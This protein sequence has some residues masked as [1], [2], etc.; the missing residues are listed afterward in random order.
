MAS[1]GHVV[2][3]PAMSQRLL[4]LALFSCACTNEPG[5]TTAGATGDTTPTTDDS[6][7]ATDTPTSGETGDPDDGA[8][9]VM[10]L[11]AN[12]TE[13]EEGDP[14]T[15]TAIVVDS[16]GLDTIVGG[17]LLT[18]DESGFYGAFSL[19]GGG[20]FQLVTSWD[21]LGQTAKIEFTGASE[22]RVFRADF[23]DVDGNHGT[24]TVELTLS[25]LGA[26]AACDG[27]C[28][29]LGTDDNCSRCG[30]ACSV[31][32]QDGACF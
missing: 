9:V 15:F 23:Q 27:V 22:V 3:S 25:C 5:D 24:A 1:R 7:A 18:A 8:P 16:G 2:S 6:S 11:L 32:C 4:V 21:I 14:V 20:T 26:D 13:L 29:I 31:V 12:V 30:D 17:K 10:E 28:T 19:A